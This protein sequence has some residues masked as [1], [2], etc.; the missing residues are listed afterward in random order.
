SQTGR[1]MRLRGKGMPLL[2]GQGQGDMFIELVVETPVN[3]TSHQKELLKLF[4]EA[5]AENSPES[6]DFFS[7]VKNFWDD[8]TS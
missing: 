8:M 1:Q 3:L 4:E 5:G 2:R 6:S 7:K